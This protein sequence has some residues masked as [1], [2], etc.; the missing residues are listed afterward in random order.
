[1]PSTKP[2]PEGN[3]GNVQNQGLVGQQSSP[4]SWLPQE[5]QKLLRPNLPHGIVLKMVSRARYPGSP[6][7]TA[8]I[9]GG[10]S[11]SSRRTSS[12]SASIFLSPNQLRERRRSSVPAIISTLSPAIGLWQTWG[13]S[14][15]APEQQPAGVDERQHHTQRPKEALVAARMPHEFQHVRVWVIPAEGGGLD[16]ERVRGGELEC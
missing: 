15:D 8:G 4:R 7:A 16:E 11:P 3:V 12:S 5:S 14:D 9:I 10:P 13:V 1:M 6:D 2:V